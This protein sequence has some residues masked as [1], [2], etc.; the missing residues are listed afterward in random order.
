M[1]GSKFYID[2]VRIFIWSG[3][4]GGGSVHWRRE[5]YVPVGGPDGGGRWEKVEALSFVERKTTLDT[6]HLNKKPHSVETRNPEG[7]MRSGSSGRYYLE[8]P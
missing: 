4:G 5:K 2:Y 7:G 1:E 6:L 3:N 8:V